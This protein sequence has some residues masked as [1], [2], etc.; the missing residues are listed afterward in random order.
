MGA[1]TGFR[2]GYLS[3]GLP[4]PGDYAVSDARRLRYAIY[5]AWYQNNQY[6]ALNDWAVAMKRDQG[7]YKHIRGIYNPPTG[8]RSSG[9]RTCGAGCLTRWRVMVSRAL[10]RCRS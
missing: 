1:I 9:E 7:L 5:W 3:A 10:P 4:D 2:E 6:R 8:W